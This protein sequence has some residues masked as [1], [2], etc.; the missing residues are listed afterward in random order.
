MSD[1]CRWTVLGE[2]PCPRNL[3]G[4]GSDTPASSLECSCGLCQ[5]ETVIRS[6]WV[7]E[8]VIYVGGQPWESVSVPETLRGG[9]QI[10]L[11][12]HWNVAV[13]C[14]NL[15]KLQE[16]REWLSDLCRWTASVSVGVKGKLA[17]FVFDVLQGPIKGSTIELPVQGQKI[18]SFASKYMWNLERTSDS[19]CRMS[20]QDECFRKNYSRKSNYILLTYILYCMRF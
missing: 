7:S 17:S 14:A 16:V 8:W 6:K 3:E 4:W 2:C 10:H 20:V 15:K 9:V 12:H 5:S 18:H 19:S 13:I 1:L 11:H